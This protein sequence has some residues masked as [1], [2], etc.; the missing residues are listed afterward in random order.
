MDDSGNMVDGCKTR[1]KILTLPQEGARHTESGVRGAEPSF[2]QR[3]G[4]E[5]AAYVTQNKLE[6]NMLGK[7]TYMRGFQALSSGPR[8]AHPHPRSSSYTLTLPSLPP[9]AMQTGGPRSTD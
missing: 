9:L 1:H 2:L 7:G 3:M 8:D 4:T 5:S 6:R